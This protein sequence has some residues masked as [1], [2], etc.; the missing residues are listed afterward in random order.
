MTLLPGA[1]GCLVHC[2]SP[3]MAGLAIAIGQA[4]QLNIG[5]FF[6]TSRVSLFTG[7]EAPSLDL[8]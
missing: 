4:G 5:V 3:G 1:L 6:N 7:F 2:T 8:L